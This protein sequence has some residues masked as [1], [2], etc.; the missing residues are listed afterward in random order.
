MGE[1]ILS[2]RGESITSLLHDAPGY[3]ARLMVYVSRAEALLRVID[4]RTSSNGRLIGQDLLEA[5][6]RRTAPNDMVLTVLHPIRIEGPSER[7]A[8]AETLGLEALEA[9]ERGV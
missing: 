8:A 5:V 3:R 1:I 6:I 2:M 9:H 4:A 7:V